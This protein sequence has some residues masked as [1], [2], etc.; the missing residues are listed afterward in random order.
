MTATP[1]ETPPTT[2]P[3]PTPAPVPST[4]PEQ[5]AIPRTTKGA[6]EEQPQT[7][8][9]LR[10]NHAQLGAVITAVQAG[11]NCQTLITQLS[12]V[13]TALNKACFYIISTEM[14]DCLARTPADETPPGALS[15]EE[16][17]KL[18]L[19]LT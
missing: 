6:D 9:A 16:I 8:N 7:M 18:F 13:Q 10:R 3:E 5:G 17:R 15:L 11:T 4:A 12:A 2:N 19:T 14:R 1:T